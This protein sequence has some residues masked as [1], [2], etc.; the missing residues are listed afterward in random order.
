[1]KSGT[2]H[3]FL[4][5]RPSSLGDIL[6]LTPA[7][8]CLR[9]AYP[10]ARIDVL[11][12]PRFQELLIENPHVS[13]LVFLE[14]PADWG[15]LSNLRKRLRQQYEIV[16]D[17]HTGLRSSYLRK[18]L[19]A[20]RILTY[21]KRRLPRW[22]LVKFKRDFYGEEFS[23]PKAY[24][25][26]MTSLDVRDDGGGLD[27]PLAFSRREKFLKLISL[28]QSPQLRPIALCPGASYPT[29]C[30]PIENWRELA[31]KLLARGDTLWV[32]GDETDRDDGEMLRQLN[33]SR[34]TNLCGNLS[35]AESGAG[36]SFCRLAVTHDAGPSH[37]ASAVGVPMVAIF[38]STVV[39]F[40]FR[41]FRIPHRIAEV[42]LYCRPCSHLGWE[43]C[44]LGHF[45][46]M[47]D[48]KAD[49]VI[50]LFAELERETNR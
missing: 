7:I 17:L 6:L 34:V 43:V 16:V 3:S 22:L 9:K 10:S 12:R 8:R 18:R 14:D 33:P 15:T 47:K 39:R 30:W 31:E 2:D 28:N 29:K 21:H 46:C 41:P 40:G 20:E 38:G 32:F 26:A 44:P 11:I 13:D 23:V 35:L 24:L 4:L 37:M 49:R 5:I 1:M 25:E 45:R 36:L 19:G 50:E 42:E 48:L 27:W